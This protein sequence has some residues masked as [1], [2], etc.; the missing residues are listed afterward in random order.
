MH[1][2]CVVQRWQDA[3]VKKSRKSKLRKMKLK[4]TKINCSHE[5]YV[6][7]TDLNDYQNL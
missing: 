3:H 6:N 2:V 1:T 5:F 4:K 7:T